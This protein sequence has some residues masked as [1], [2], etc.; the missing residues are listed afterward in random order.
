MSWPRV[1]Q[2]PNDL[3]DEP[4]DFRPLDI[5]FTGV[6]GMMREAIQQANLGGWADGYTC[7]EKHAYGLAAALM[8]DHAKTS[9]LLLLV[10]HLVKRSGQSLEEFKGTH[11]WPAVP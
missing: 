2:Q 3:G 8:L 5:L 1:L 9:E 11:T 4:S 7:G 6:Q 10:E